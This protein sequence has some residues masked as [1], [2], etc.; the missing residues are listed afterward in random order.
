MRFLNRKML[1]KATAVFLVLLIM[2]NILQPTVIYALTLGPTQPEY[3]SYQQPGSTDMV[4]LMTGDFTFSL[5]M[6]EVP[7]PEGSF[8][9]PLTYNAGI[10][11]EQEASWVGLGWTVN[12]GCLTRSIVGFPDDA[13]GEAQSVTVQDLTGVHGW[14]THIAGLGT[15]G[16][17]SAVGNYGSISILG[18]INAQWK[19]NKTSGGFLGFNSFGNDPNFDGTQFAIGMITIIS[20]GIASAAAEGAGEAFSLGEEIG[21]QAFIGAAADAAISTLASA[22]GSSNS[23]S[24]GY[25]PYTTEENNNDWLTFLSVGAIRVR[26]YKTWLD[27]SRVEQMYGMM[28]LGNA[29]TVEYTNTNPDF[30][31]LKLQIGGASRTLNTFQRT[32]G[33]SNQGAASDINYKPSSNNTLAFWQ[34]NNPALLATDHFGVK[35]PGISGSIQPYRLEIGSVSMPREM[36]SNHDRLAPVAYLANDANYKV[37]FIYRGQLS[38]R[39]F[40]HVGGST[41]VTNPNINYGINSI[42]SPG[43]TVTFDLNDVI[44]ESQRISSDVPASKRIPQANYIEWLTNDEIRNGITYPSKFID[45]LSGGSSVS[46]TSDRYLFRTKA[47]ASNLYTTS[48][49]T[50]FSN[51]AIPVPSYFINNLNSATVDLFMTFYA[52]QTNRDQGISN[53]YADLKGLSVASINATNNTFSISNSVLYSYNGKIA[54]IQITVVTNLTTP[55]GFGSLN[56]IGGF[57]ITSSNGMTYHFAMPVYD[58]NQ[59]SEMRDSTDPNNKKTIIKRNPAFANNW[60]LTALTGPDFIDRGGSNN[61]GNGL[62][63]DSDWGYWVKFNYGLHTSAYTWRMPFSGYRHEP[64]ALNYESYSTGNN[65]LVYL[66]SIETRSHVA[67]FLKGPRSDGRSAG[68][69]GTSPL[70][71]EEIALISKEVYNSLVSSYGLPQLSSSISSMCLSSYFINNNPPRNFLNLNCLKRIVFNYDYSLCNPNQIPNLV[72]N[73]GTGKLTLKSLSVYGRSNIKAIPDYK[74]DYANNPAYDPNLWDGWGSYNNSNGILQSTQHTTYAPF[75]DANGSAWSLTKITNPIGSEINVNYE[76]D[77]YSLISG[78][79]IIDVSFGFDLRNTSLFYPIDIP[80]NGQIRTLKVNVNGNLK[81]GDRVFFDGFVSYTCPNGSTKNKPLVNTLTRVA[82]V[83]A[84]N[85]IITFDDYFLNVSDCGNFSSG[86]SV[87]FSSFYGNINRY[88]DGKKGEGIRVASIITKNEFGQQKKIRYLYTNPD[89]VV[90]SGV[91]AQE[92]VHIGIPSEIPGYPNTP[93]IYG[94]VTTLNGKLTTD[95]DFITKSIY[96]FETPDA[97]QYV[98]SQR[99]VYNGE[100]ALDSYNVTLRPST[101]FGEPDH[102]IVLGKKLW[103]QLPTAPHGN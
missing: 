23:P 91:V 74:F 68:T 67:L 98:L 61:T 79:P 24:D 84:V 45:F 7:G 76:R 90:S 5:P 56:G 85:N 9:V 57:C 25:F 2:E 33:S 37:P 94:Q 29:P 11:L 87:S 77:S 14:D 71:L 83:D 1:K 38:N 34:V 39:Y 102:A 12:A 75:A 50:N 59:Y 10:G 82:S 65:Q 49:T 6:L 26:D 44:F 28:Y 73:A 46:T 63:D 35:A 60:L 70:R 54:D 32:V 96:Q 101:S 103:I 20:F 36:T 55:N 31:T 93:V 51:A 99:D 40:H 47:T 19:G 62:I 8:S 97:S 69:D 64:G 100:C 16:Y 48:S 92:P 15:F 13:N 80:T 72:P 30:A 17:N 88:S 41:S 3:T 42:S 27:Q 53:G 58:Y 22:F 86:Q 66:N 18:I 4:N 89:G 43:P 78:N 21:K 52:D 95:S 81:Q